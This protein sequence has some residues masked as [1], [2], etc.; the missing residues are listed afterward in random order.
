MVTMRFMAVAGVM[1]VVTVKLAESGLGSQVSQESLQ[2]SW[3]T[4]RPEDHLRAGGAEM[5]RCP[6]FIGQSV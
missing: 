4:Q 3:K 1:V 5:G 2:Q 6:G